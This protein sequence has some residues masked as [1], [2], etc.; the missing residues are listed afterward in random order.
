MGALI[1]F[2]ML[3]N[4]FT[5]A[6]DSEGTQKPPLSEWLKKAFECIPRKALRDSLEGSTDPEPIKL[7]RLQAVQHRANS[8][9]PLLPPPERNMEGRRTLVLD[10]DETLVHADTQAAHYNFRVQFHTGSSTW[11]IGVSTRPGVEEFLAE[12]AKHFEIVVFTASVE[13]YAEAVLERIDP[14]GH[15]AHILGRTACIKTP[16]GWVKDLTRLGRPLEEIVIVDDNEQSYKNNVAN[17]LPVTSWFN[18]AA[19]R[20]LAYVTALLTMIAENRCSAVSVLELMD[21][22]LRWHRRDHEGKPASHN[23]M[24]NRAIRG[25]QTFRR[26]R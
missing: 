10:L 18:D 24:R 3:R 9:S 23:V 5:F 14:H 21:Q 11:D 13:A 15:V 12:A 19:D 17:A 2:T 20:E 8:K 4:G 16:E 25:I 6:T 7:R 22:E 26:R 1:M